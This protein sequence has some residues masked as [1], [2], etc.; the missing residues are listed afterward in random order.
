MASL[1]RLLRGGGGGGRSPGF[2]TDNPAGKAVVRIA[3]AFRLG[4]LLKAATQKVPW[5]T[6]GGFR[7]YVT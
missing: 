5:F 2:S 1:G 6:F 3:Q 4:Y 7:D